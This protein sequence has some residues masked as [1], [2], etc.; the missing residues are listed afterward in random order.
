ME[1]RARAA[2]TRVSAWLLA[3]GTEAF[4]GAL[5]LPAVEMARTW[6]GVDS[7]DGLSWALS[8]E[9]TY[10]TNAFL[11][12][13]FVVWAAAVWLRWRPAW[14]IGII[15]SVGAALLHPLIGA[16]PGFERI[17]R[18]HVGY[19]V[20]DA[21]TAA[22]CAAFLVLPDPAGSAAL[23]LRRA[24]VDQ[25]RVAL[26]SM[27]GGGAIA[28]VLGLLLLFT[29]TGVS[30]SVVGGP[31]THLE[32]IV[33][34]DA[35]IAPLGALILLLSAGLLLAASTRRGAWRWG[36]AAAAVTATV[37]TSLI[38]RPLQTAGLPL[39][40]LDVL[41]IATPAL[42]LAAFLLLPARVRG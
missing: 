27:F 19:W 1:P 4:W 12:L 42:F 8:Y 28:L 16:W 9:P 24:D 36:G 37:L 35:R 32:F 17:G 26:S 18:L 10:A 31:L 20:W 5:A 14:I 30:S 41:W 40:P 33:A 29:S 7:L 6:Q 15:F 11:A 25:F 21:A 22:I 13:A 3:V 38:G 2:R 34:H 23:R 39:Q